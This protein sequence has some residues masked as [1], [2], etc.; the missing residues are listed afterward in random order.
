MR[1]LLLATGQEKLDN[2]IET[3]VIKDLDYTV[4]DKI[5]YKKDLINSVR[6]HNP[7]LIIVSKS[8]LGRDFTMLEL[9]INL[10]NEFPNIRV[11]YL[12]GEITDA[13]VEKY[14]ELATLV[15][16]GIYDI[17]HEKSIKINILRNLI[18]E[19]KQREDVQYLF[20]HM[21]ANVIYEDEIVDIE[22]EEVVEDIEKD[23][24]KNIY[25]VSSIKP[26]TGKSFVS[27]NMATNIAKYGVKKNGKAPK[28]ALIEADLQNL[29][30]GT[31][32]Q[33]EEK[34][35]KN[36]K[37]VMDKIATILDEEGNLIDNTAD[38]RVKIDAVNKFILGCFE[39][40]K[41]CKNL[42]TLV[43]SD[44]LMSQVEDIK[45]VY[46]NYLLECIVDDFDVIIVDTNSSLAHVTTYPLLRLCNTAYYVINL[47]FNNIRNNTKYK[48]TL[49]DLE[50]FN[51]VKYVLNEDI[52]EEYRD[53]IGRNLVEPLLFTADEVNENHF[54]TVA[55]I[56]EIPKEIFLN[57]LYEGRPI[58]LDD[59]DYTLKARIE[60]GNVCNEIWE[61]ENYNYL[62]GEYSKYRAKIDEIKN[63]KRK[64]PFFFK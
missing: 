42:Y 13:N 10:K 58:V 38:D 16:N 17:I 32:L 35:D 30:I 14:N 20:K 43:G 24:Y 54:D 39:Q 7:E 52:D 40:Y 23:G 36:L 25:I 46:Y 21:K 48:N 41:E 34:K 44:L 6:N 64:K 12:A 56:P 53:L 27:T 61:I 9:L 1:K 37:A 60:I 15:M 11:I 50:V 22:E 31:L 28:V 19:P 49:K 45:P 57:R 18:L 8:L 59:T 51:K 47:D 3:K 55:K 33:I 26:G 62:C 4:V 29:S 63:N 2:I 5:I